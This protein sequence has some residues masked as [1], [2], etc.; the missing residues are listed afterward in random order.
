MVYTTYFSVVRVMA[1][2]GTN[3]TET[4]YPDN[5]DRA[6]SKQEEPQITTLTHALPLSVETVFYVW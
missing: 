4:K 3:D 1:R 6:Q 2:L 5:P